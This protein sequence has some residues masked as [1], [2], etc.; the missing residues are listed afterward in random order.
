[1]Y[2]D[3]WYIVLLFAPSRVVHAL[4]VFSL[5]PPLEGW[6]EGGV[7]AKRFAETPA[8]TPLGRSRNPPSSQISCRET[9]FLG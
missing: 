7:A 2:V 4:L 1:M 8:A 3:I 9:P 5:E 6:Q